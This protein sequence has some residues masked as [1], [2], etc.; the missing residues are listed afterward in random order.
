M[1]W[2][3]IER[4]TAQ[5]LQLEPAARLSRQQLNHVMV[6]DALHHD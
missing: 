6:S 5:V 3:D 4:L 1:T 2:A